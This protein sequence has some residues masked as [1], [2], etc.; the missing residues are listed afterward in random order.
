ML[1]DRIDEGKKSEVM[2]AIETFKET[3]AST[4]YADE[5]YDLSRVL[6]SKWSSCVDGYAAVF[7]KNEKI[8]EENPLPKI[9]APKLTRLLQKSNNR[10]VRI[11]EWD[12][13]EDVVN[14]VR[15][16]PYFPLPPSPEL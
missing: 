6:Y 15:R 14:T 7:E 16:S 10:A 1:I 11:E 8:D 9:D 2:K 12:T 3:G 13:W 4:R 5:L